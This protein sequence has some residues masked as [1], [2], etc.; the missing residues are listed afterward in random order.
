MESPYSRLRRERV[1]HLVGES[2]ALAPGCTGGWLDRVLARRRRQRRPSRGRATLPRRRLAFLGLLCALKGALLCSLL[3]HWVEAAGAGRMRTVQNAPACPVAIVFGARVFA[4]G[5]PSA[6][7]RARL[8]TALDLYR[9]G[10]VEKLLVSGDNRRSHYNEPEAM[11]RWL[12]A[13]GVAGVDVHCDYAGFRTL[14][15]CARA[16][17]V[18]GLDR[19]LLVTQRYHLPR[20]LFLAQAWGLRAVGV[21][22][23]EWASR[24]DRLREHFACVMAWVD[25]EVFCRGP[26]FLGPAEDLWPETPPAVQFAAV[27]ER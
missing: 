18:W 2:A 9:S 23:G 6:P 5:T 17:H 10:R 11:R 7:L 22:A 16:R 12:R 24:R 14:D 4:D 13:R 15:T 21:S 3:A 25:T 27:D 19:A 20:A 26:R 1:Q 8:Q